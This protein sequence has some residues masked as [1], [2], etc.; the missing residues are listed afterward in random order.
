VRD[1]RAPGGGLGGCPGVRP[2][3]AAGALFPCRLDSRACCV[4]YTLPDLVVCNCRWAPF[5]WLPHVDGRSVQSMLVV[6]APPDPALRRNTQSSASCHRH[7]PGP[8]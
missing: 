6:R 2:P 8:N 7:R 1:K 4:V 3:P 5:A